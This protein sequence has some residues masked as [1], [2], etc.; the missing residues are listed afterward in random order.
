MLGVSTQRHNFGRNICCVGVRN[1][2]NL[3]EFHDFAYTIC[4]WSDFGAQKAEWLQ[5]LGSLHVI[6]RVWDYKASRIILQTY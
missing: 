2:D 6:Q 4:E 1:G 3:K 5:K